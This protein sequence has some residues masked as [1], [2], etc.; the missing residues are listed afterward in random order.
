MD[1]HPTLIRTGWE[2]GFIAG[3]WPVWHGFRDIRNI[4][5]HT[6]D[7]DKAI[8]VAAKVPAFL[9]EAKVHAGSLAARLA[10]ESAARRPD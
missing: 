8:A 1:I 7:V 9:N 10:A 4:T 5:S 6:Y 2:Q 3:G